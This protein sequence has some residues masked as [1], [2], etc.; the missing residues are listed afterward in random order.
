LL[1]VRL[2]KN[3]MFPVS[4][5]PEAPP[6]DTRQSVASGPSLA[7]QAWMTFIDSAAVG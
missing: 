6:K 2:L 7:L 5:K 1:V 4:S 3:V